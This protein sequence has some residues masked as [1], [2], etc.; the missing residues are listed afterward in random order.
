MY[1]LWGNNHS[2]MKVLG[3]LF[4]NHCSGGF[5]KPLNLLN[6]PAKH[7]GKKCFKV[8][9]QNPEQTLSSHSLLVVALEMIKIRN[10]G[11]QLMSL[12]RGDVSL[13]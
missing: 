4:A 7:Q 10:S 6:L 13:R 2:K 12:I 9:P 5:T 1:F 11:S 8:P 3:N